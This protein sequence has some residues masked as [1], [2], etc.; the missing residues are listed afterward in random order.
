MKD[1][2]RRIDVNLEEL[3]RVLDGAREAPLSEADCDKLKN[4]LHA[5]AAM[6]TQTRHTEKTSAVLEEPENPETGDGTQPDTDVSP[7]PGHGRNSADEFTG[8]KKVDV[9]HP[10]LQHGDRCPECGTVA[11]PKTSEFR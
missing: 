11:P 8:A 2:R 9:P 1:A 3:D 10:C 4:A 7:Q 6:L 5:L